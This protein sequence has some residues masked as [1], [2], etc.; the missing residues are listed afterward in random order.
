MFNE[1]D[2]NND[3]GGD[4]GDGGGGCCDGNCV[5]CWGELTGGGALEAVKVV[6]SFFFRNVELESES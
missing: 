5:A 4:H 2:D 6:F 3:G 1:E